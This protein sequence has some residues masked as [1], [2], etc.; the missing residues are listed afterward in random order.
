[1]RRTDRLCLNIDD[2]GWDDAR[3]YLFDEATATLYFPVAK[4][5]LP[6][7]GEGFRVLIWSQPRIIV[8]GDLLPATS[9]DD[10]ILQLSLAEAQA[11]QPD[12]AR[13]MLLDQRTKKPRRSR[14]KL[15]IQLIAT[16]EA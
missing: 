4:R 12:K 7:R 2:P 14:H 15:V 8:T 11:M 6:E 3:G 16:C 1:M 13:F 9:D 5:Y 10:F